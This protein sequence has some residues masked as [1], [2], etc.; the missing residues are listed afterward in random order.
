MLSPSS[1]YSPKV[2]ISGILQNRFYYIRQRVELGSTEPQS[3]PKKT[4]MVLQTAVE[5]VLVQV[6]AA[7]GNLPDR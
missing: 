2:T 5:H 6:I 3:A 4:C 1:H 7:A